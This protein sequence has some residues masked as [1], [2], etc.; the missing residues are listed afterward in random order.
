MLP[1][2][3][4]DGRPVGKCHLVDGL[5]PVHIDQSGTIRCACT[6]SIL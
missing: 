2:L 3:S 5:V 1:L 6:G 4:A